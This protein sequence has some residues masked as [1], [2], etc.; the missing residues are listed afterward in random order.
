MQSVRTSAYTQRV[1][2]SI[3]LLTRQGLIP[4]SEVLTAMQSVYS[5]EDDCTVSDGR[6][7][8]NVIALFKA[9]GGVVGTIYE[10]ELVSNWL[11]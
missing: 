6:K 9:L 8:M 4:F 10:A 1:R 7:M 11:W 3:S 5:L 2:S